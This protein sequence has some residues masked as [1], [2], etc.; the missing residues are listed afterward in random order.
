MIRMMASLPARPAALSCAVALAL[1]LHAGSGVAQTTPAAAATNATTTTAP[2]ATLK[3][4]TPV[5]L[6]MVPLPSSRQQMDMTMSLRMTM[7]LVLPPDAPAQAREIAAQVQKTMPLTMT[8]VMRQ[9]MQTAAK[10]ADGSYPLEGAGDHARCRRCAMRRGRRSRCRPRRPSRFK[11]TIRDDRI[12]AIEAHIPNGTPEQGRRCSPRKLQEKLF[13]QTFD[14]VRKFNDVTLKVG[15][16]IEMPLELAL[17]MAPSSDAEESADGQVHAGV[18]Q[19]R[20]WRCSTSAC[21]WR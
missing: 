8:A 19:A 4:G 20:A 9:Q 16:S 15:E 3:A 5:R 11:A 2:A 21:A 13:N 17:P 18:G 7:A 10:T 1:S 12:D 14:W 6:M